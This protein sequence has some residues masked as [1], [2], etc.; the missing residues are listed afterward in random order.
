MNLAVAIDIYAGGPG[1]GCNPEKAQPRCGR[2]SGSSKELARSKAPGA[3]ARPKAIHVKT[4]MEAIKLIE[5]GKVV[6]L[7]NPNQVHTLLEN[8]AYYANTGAKKG[9][10]FDLCKV[11]LKGA[12]IFCVGN[13]DVPR[14][15]MPQFAGE[16][17]PGSEADKLPRS[18]FDPKNVDATEHFVSYLKD[19]GIGVK[20]DR[21]YAA[22][23]RA[24]QRELIG[25]KVAGIMKT[26]KFD[27][28]K[29]PIFISRDNYVVDGHHRW[30]AVV[31]RDAAD[32]KLGNLKMNAIRIDAPIS[33]VL[34][35][36]NK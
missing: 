26:T 13:L 7:G 28:T 24:S 4:V 21:V 27:I 8:L 2:P 18:K 33:E 17:V 20:N 10:N 12:S 15:Q 30:A 16:P 3:T 29:T 34:L 22:Y 31:G 1:S 6:E 35:E 11:T 25:T 32:N 36:A 14:I 9:V 19:K 5:Q 23:L